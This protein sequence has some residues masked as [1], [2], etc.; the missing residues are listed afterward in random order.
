MIVYLHNNS[1]RICLNIQFVIDVVMKKTK[2]YASLV[3]RMIVIL[4]QYLK[5]LKF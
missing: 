3:I 5:N 4:N 2:K 1:L